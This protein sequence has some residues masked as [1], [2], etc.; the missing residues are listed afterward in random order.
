MSPV[1]ETPAQ[2]ELV[3]AHKCCSCHREAIESSTTCGCFYCLAIFSPAEITTW[4]QETRRGSG[5]T[6]MCPN[7]NIDTVLGSA[8]GFPIT[9]EFLQRMRDCWFA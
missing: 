1:D 7:C 9:P 5:E 3:D 4:H 2:Q 8:S 6:A